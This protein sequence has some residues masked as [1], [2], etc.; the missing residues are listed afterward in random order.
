MNDETSRSRLFNLKQ[1]GVEK[2]ASLKQKLSDARGNR[3]D[4][5][6][7]DTTSES[8]HAES[9]HSEPELLPHLCDTIFEPQLLRNRHYFSAFY[10]SSKVLTVH[11][12]SVESPPLHV[13]SLPPKTTNILLTDHLIYAINKE[14]GAVNVVS[15]ELTEFRIESDR[16]EDF[17][18]NV[19]PF[20]E[21]TLIA[22]FTLENEKILRVFKQTDKPVLRAR[23]CKDDDK[24]EKLY[25]LPKTVD[26][27][28]IQKPRVDT[29]VIVT[30]C[31]VYKVFIR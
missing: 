12:S 22:D 4:S 23:K 25:E 29:C 13:Y 14:D 16:E 31:S 18:Q 26:D 30:N 24:K 19:D 17:L 2:F 27:L 5:Q 3:R 7:S 15:T 9:N 21:D 20:F 6:T 10:R 28:N 11:E 8:S 1:L